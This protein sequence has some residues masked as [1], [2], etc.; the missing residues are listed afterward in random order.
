M[1]SRFTRACIACLICLV[2]A[3]CAAEMG[4]KPVP[5]DAPFIVGKT[6]KAEVIE[7]LGLPQEISKDDA[8]T[9]HYWYEPSA[10]L[11]GLCVGCAFSSNTAG[12]VPGAA[13]E[14][15]AASAKRNRAQLTFD[16]SGVL[17][18]YLPPPH[19]EGR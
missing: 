8:G 19:K 2:L 9:E 4:V 7:A 5:A 18:E 1:S 17:V 16:A 15:S 13:V 3:A 6:T 12:A 10:R 14:S 11:T